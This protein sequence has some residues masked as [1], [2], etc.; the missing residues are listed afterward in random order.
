LIAFLDDRSRLIIQ[1]EILE[2]KTLISTVAGLRRAL[3][4]PNIVIPHMMTIDNAGEF[5]G[6]DF[7]AVL[8]EYRIKDWRTT[9]YTPGQNG[10]M[11]RW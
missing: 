5:V 6:A 7:Q 2:N 10:K 1:H 3:C 11:E 9:P 4:Q 8:D